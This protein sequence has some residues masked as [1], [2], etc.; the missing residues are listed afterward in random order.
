MLKIIV[1][2][3]SHHGIGI[4]N[5]LPWSIKEDL[6]QFRKLT[7]GHGVLMGRKT[8]DSIGHALPDRTNYVVSRQKNLPYENIV[9]VQD[10]QAFLSQKQS[11]SDTVYV[12]G[13]ASLYALAMDY[14]N[15]LIISEVKG[16]YACD[17]FFTSFDPDRF[18]LIETIEFDQFTR[19]RYVRKTS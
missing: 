19:K 2:M 14:V 13:G 5:R 16:V 18:D 12:I 15:E 4:D 9:L 6:K 11:S 10:I 8:L 1:A 17:T 7:L 3:D